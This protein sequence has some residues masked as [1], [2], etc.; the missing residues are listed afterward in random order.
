MNGLRVCPT[1][2]PWDPREVWWRLLWRNFPPEYKN[3]SLRLLCSPLS[4]LF[5]TL[6]CEDVMLGAR[7]AYRDT[8]CLTVP[9][10]RIRSRKD[11]MTS[12]ISLDFCT[13]PG[14]KCPRL[15]LCEIIK[16]LNCLITCLSSTLVFITKGFLTLTA[17][18]FP[19]ASHLYSYFLTGKG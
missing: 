1:L 12:V 3:H 2:S 10:Y 5:G 11:P 7:A 14:N 15:L 13:N 18:V 4:C 16:C 19:Q 9:R 17:P 8:C 6:S